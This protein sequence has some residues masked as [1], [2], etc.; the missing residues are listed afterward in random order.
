MRDNTAE[1]EPEPIL[2]FEEVVFNGN[3]TKTPIEMSLASGELAFLKSRSVWTQ[4]SGIEDV[5][6][7]EIR[8]LS[9]SWDSRSV[10]D[11]EDDRR[12]IGTVVNPRS[13]SS[14]RWVTNLDV[15]ENVKLSASFDQ[16]RSQ[17]SI[18]ERVRELTEQF[19]LEGG[20]PVLRPSRV[21]DADLIRAQWVRAFLPDPL[22]LL[23]LENPLFHAP[24]SAREL[25]IEAVKGALD[26]GVAVLW[27]AEI[28][29]SFSNLGLEPDLLLD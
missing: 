5:V 25:L 3:K 20:L 12:T 11:C 18:D 6:S 24:A 7:G 8:F 2:E 15:N 4:I 14:A 1:P 19:G 28:K 17:N 26:A 16:K 10:S 13:Q 29:P 27:V 21:G 23:V 22:N 9:E